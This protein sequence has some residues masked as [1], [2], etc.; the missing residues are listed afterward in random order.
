MQPLFMVKAEL[1]WKAT[2]NKAALHSQCPLRKGAQGGEL[3]LQPRRPSSECHRALLGNFHALILIAIGNVW[4]DK[5]WSP[6]GESLRSRGGRS[7]AFA[8]NLVMLGGNWCWVNN[9]N[10]YTAVQSLGYVYTFLHVFLHRSLIQCF[11]QMKHLYWSPCTV[12]WI[13]RQSFSATNTH[14]CACLMN[15][16]HPWSK[17]GF[18]SN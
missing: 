14:V 6:S 13:C 5:W 16:L 15:D 18:S 2:A 7:C 3:E 17:I 4:F 10:K 11:L 12:I 8:P 9:A 1:Q